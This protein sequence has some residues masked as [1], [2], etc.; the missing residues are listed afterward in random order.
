MPPLTVN[1]RWIRFVFLGVTV[2]AF[3]ISVLKS[4]F[5]ALL[6]VH[7]GFKALTGLPCLLCGGTRGFCA[8]LRGDFAYALYLNPISI[9]V[10]SAAVFFAVV[11]A[12]EILC[13]R[14]LADWHAASRFLFKILPFLIA[15]LLFLW[16]LHIHSA[17]RSPKSELVDFNKPIAARLRAWLY[18]P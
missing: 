7:C 12:V 13:G 11:C 18:Q 14:P 6:G 4:L 2:L 8:L 17:L 1:Q 10:L 9:A 16:G 5:P 3:A 15:L